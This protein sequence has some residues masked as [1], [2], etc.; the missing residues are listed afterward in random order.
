LPKTT[1]EKTDKLPVTK[2]NDE[3]CLRFVNGHTDKMMLPQITYKEKTIVFMADLT[4]SV[5]HL[6]VPYVMAYD[7]FP[8]TTLQE[9]KSFLQE[10][11]DKEYILFFEHDATIE[12]CTLQQ[13]ERGIR[14]KDIFKLSEI[15]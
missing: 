10:A 13:T 7:M 9:K 14:Q 8:F 6:P 12:C 1:L 11:L 4:P 5:A 15:R 2:F 3:I